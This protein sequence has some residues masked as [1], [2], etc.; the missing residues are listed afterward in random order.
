[1]HEEE[2]KY[3]LVID[4]GDNLRNDA[5]DKESSGLPRAN[6]QNNKGTHQPLFTINLR[7]KNFSTI[8]EESR[9]SSHQEGEDDAENAQN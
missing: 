9:E 5:L 6:M 3:E 8:Y 1:M 4:D 7:K 2:E